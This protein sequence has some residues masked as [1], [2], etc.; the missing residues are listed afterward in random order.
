MN[1]SPG[2]TGVTALPSGYEA[3][4]ARP[5][6][7]ATSGSPGNG[8]KSNMTPAVE[9]ADADTLCVIVGTIHSGGS[10]VA[11]SGSRTPAARSCGCSG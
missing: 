8:S 6:E 10:T 2:V 4:A 1:Q 5:A 3:L 7:L 9:D 11:G